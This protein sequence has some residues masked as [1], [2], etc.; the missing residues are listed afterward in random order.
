MRRKKRKIKNTRGDGTR[1]R[2][3]IAPSAEEAGAAPLLLAD[4]L[5]ALNAIRDERMVL[6]LK[7]EGNINIGSN[8]DNRTDLNITSRENDDIEKRREGH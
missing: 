3:S 4:D 1:D 6:R 5:A 2:S 7:T 8:D